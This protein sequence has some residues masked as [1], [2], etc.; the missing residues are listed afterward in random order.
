M[1]QQ[2]KYYLIFLFGFLFFIGNLQ[3]QNIIS[4]AGLSFQNTQFSVDYVVG[5]LSVMT[6]QNN[7]NILT[8]GFLQPIMTKTIPT[9]LLDNSLQYSLIYFP[10]PTDKYVLIQSNYTD[11]KKFTLTDILGRQLFNQDLE[12][13][14]LNLE[15]LATGTYIINLFNS[16]SQLLKTFK[17]VKQ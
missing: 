13:N 3:A 5:E 1:K 9:G 6:L 11:L 17:I 7:Q 15:N 2:N 12:N 16:K 4:S 14:L 8:Q 10:N